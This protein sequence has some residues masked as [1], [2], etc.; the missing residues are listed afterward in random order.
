M[1]AWSALN[2]FPI[3]MLTRHLLTELSIE[4]IPAAKTHKSWRTLKP[5]ILTKCRC[6]EMPAGS[7]SKR[8]TF[9]GFTAL[10][11]AFSSTAW[12]PGIPTWK[13]KIWEKHWHWPLID[14]PLS[15]VYTMSSTI[16]PPLFSHRACRDTILK[17]S[18][19]PAIWIWPWNCSNR[20]WKQRRKTYRHL[21][22]YQPP[23]HLR[24]RRNWP[25]SKQ[26]GINWAY[27]YAS[28]T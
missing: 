25:L 16:W 13:T 8:Q 18:W 28:N 23:D 21:K 10:P 20:Q 27:R 9:N 22:S 12:T 2:A 24:Q 26:H 11:W 7:W 3:I 17:I 4:F 6:S 14:K 15:A 5:G 19:R 1:T